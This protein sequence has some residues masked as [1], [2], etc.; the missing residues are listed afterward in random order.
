MRKTIASIILLLAAAILPAGAQ[1]YVSERVYVSTD[2]DVYVAGDDLFFSAFCLDMADRTL[3]DASR[4]AYLELVSADGPV[5]TAK[6]ALEDGRGGGVIPLLNTI[7]TGNYRLVAY[8]AQCLDENGYDFL[9][10][11]RTLSIINPFTTARASSGVEILS[12]EDYRQV[13]GGN[14]HP[15]SG[16]ISL[17]TSG[18][19]TITNNTNRR[20]SLSLSVYHD[21]GIPSPQ[22][23]NPVSFT[24]NATSGRNFSDSRARDNE[25][26]I[27]SARLVGTAA[28]IAAAQGSQAFLSVPGRIEDLYSGIIGEDGTVAFYTR[29]IYGDT[30]LVLDPGNSAGNS[31]L[32]IISPFAGVKD[33][34][35]PSLPLSSSLQERI[36]QRSL[37]MQVM[38]ATGAD[39]LYSVLP[40]PAFTPFNVEPI[41]YNLDDY[42]RFPLMEELFI[43]YI[44]EAGIRR[45]R[46][47]RDLSVSLRD[48]LRSVPY[49]SQPCLVL[50]DGVPV[51]DHNLMFEYD[52]LL[53]EKIAI[54]P[55]TF[56]LGGRTYPG[57]L[58]FITYKRNLPSYT[59]G[60]NVRVVEFQGVSYPVVSWLP[61]TSGQMPDLRQTI[62]WH[63]EID[64]APG[65]SRTFEYC[66]PSYQGKFNVVVEGFD[67]AGSPL[68]ASGVISN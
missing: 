40:V 37:S 31:H 43:E 61:D 8:T 32:E 22:T 46:D 49:E 26:E 48:D 29:N 38:R 6:V 21:D 17:S 52:P 1:G 65:E 3:S 47:G 33:P 19:V 55:Y 25:G 50:L 20:V 18:P 64:L 13:S 59:F 57:I 4:I 15:S 7:P 12:E 42:T 45:T 54:Y 23:V 9:E 34:D 63:P 35:I 28:D 68:C 14:P 27:I 56:Y 51:P 66:L 2:R 39:S 30:D 16:G 41:V 60:D 62:L 44:A 67:A 11:A 58:N 10:G 5:Q 36:L 24:D 53:V